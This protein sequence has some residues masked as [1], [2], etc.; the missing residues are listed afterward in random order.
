MR[1]QALY[2][3]PVK[4]LGGESLA[5]AEPLERGL[6][7]D[8]RWMFVSGSQFITQ[9]TC[10]RLAK[11][12]AQT[13]GL[14]GLAFFR[15]ADGALIAQLDDAR[16]AHVPGHRV[17]LWDDTFDAA[18][19][20]DPSLQALTIE[21]GIPGA[22]LVYMNEQTNRPVDPRYAKAHEKVSFADGYP[23]LIT[24]DASLAAVE[25]TYGGSLD[26]RRFRPNI[27]VADVERA[28]DEDE[29]ADFTIGGCTFY[30][31]KP[32]AR[33][34]VITHHPDTGAVDRAV[35]RALSSIRRTAGGKILFGINC[36]LS[37][38]DGKIRLGD[39]LRLHHRKSRV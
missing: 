28:F 15:I 32:C 19:V 14:K 38:G 12:R 18:L 34:G 1:I 30:N 24:S 27:V 21:L 9:R 5:A 37:S 3:Y 2:R 35:Q 20:D 23:F 29:W 6:R 16:P 22:Q 10:R 31:A 17:Q 26:M 36:C 4:S 13:E 39:E 33:C 8:R 7:D 11:Y 25:R